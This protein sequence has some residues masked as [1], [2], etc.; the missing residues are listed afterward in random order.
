MSKRKHITIY[1]RAP[2]STLRGTTLIWF[3]TKK[4]TYRALVRDSTFAVTS[5][6]RW[7]DGEAVRQRSD[8]AAARSLIKMLKKEDV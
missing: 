7:G 3:K 2:H 5:I 8:C 4:G 1:S 6:V